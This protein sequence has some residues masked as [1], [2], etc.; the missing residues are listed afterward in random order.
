MLQILSIST[1]SQ[2]HC[3]QINEMN[4]FPITLRSAINVCHEVI[5]FAPTHNKKSFK[6]L[7]VSPHA[8]FVLLSEQPVHV[9]TF[10]SS[11][12]QICSLLKLFIV[13]TFSC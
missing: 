3:F 7:T 5:A 9:L 8:V 2:V 1:K 11:Q 12:Y 10:F 6:F 13:Q 4:G